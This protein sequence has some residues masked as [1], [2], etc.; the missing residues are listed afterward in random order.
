MVTR[1]DFLRYA[2]AGSAAALLAGWPATRAIARAAADRFDPDLALQLVAA[3]RSVS[4]RHGPPTRVWSFEAR[5]LKGEPAA[6]VTLP[7]NTYLGPILRLR[8]GQKLQVDFLNRI[9]EPSI[10]HWHGLIDPADMDGHPRYAVPPGG[11]YRYRF[12]I[13]NRAGTY[14]YHPHPD[15]LTGQQVYFGLAGLMLISDEEEQA[16]PLPRGEYDVPIVIQDRTFTDDNQLRYLPGTGPDAKADATRR[17]RTRGE[18]MASGGMM[19]MMGGGMMGRGMM[20]R[21]A[22]SGG[23]GGG[24]GGMMTRMMGFFGDTILVNGRPNGSL[25]V[26]TRAYRL[27]VVNASNSRIYKLAWSDGRPLT[28]IA[29]GAGLLERPLRKKYVMLAPAERVELWA[30]FSDD[31]A[32]T[33]LT[34]ES[35]AFS[36]T[37]GMMGGGMMGRGMM[38]GMMQGMMGDAMGGALPPGSRFPVFTVKVTRKSGERLRLP[39][40]LSTITPLRPEEAANR[41]HP[42]VFRISM[43]R[44]QWGINGRS[45]QTTAYTPE[46]TAKFNTTEIWEFVNPT[47]MAHSMH[48]HQSPF[49]VLERHNG[50]ASAEVAEGFIDQGCWRDTVLVMPGD[51]VRIIKR[52]GDYPG[53]FLYHCHMLEHEDS[54][55]MRNYFVKA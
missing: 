4:L 54:G 14:W 34:M 40:H 29:T 6:A 30:D 41:D 5:M 19:S 35:L 48:I 24:V 10:I 16:L 26:A 12:P 11:H 17:S 47:G 20:G 13:L 25:D 49:Q 42:K 45:F 55:L 28:V 22:Q 23:M 43:G 15:K 44:M 21:G 27:R 31:P 18:G 39:E 9:D 51:R 46:E 7:G 3:P 1:R 8:R 2:G 38:G 50:A 33:Q 53:L 52:F 37:M 32:G 36:G